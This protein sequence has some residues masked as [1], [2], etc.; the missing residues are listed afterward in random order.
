[1]RRMWTAIA[2]AVL[3][4]GPVACSSDSND[5]ATTTESRLEKN[6]DEV[7]V[8]TV[9]AVAPG[10]L[11]GSDVTEIIEAA[12]AACRAATDAGDDADS[13]AVMT[14]SVQG[15][16]VA[17]SPI[18]AASISGAAIGAYCPEHGPSG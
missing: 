15:A 14:Q 7:F 3:G 8:A 5:E 11:E 4:L 12:K 16:G 10:V 1:M 13:V 18:E 17:D 6:P 2:I 9:G